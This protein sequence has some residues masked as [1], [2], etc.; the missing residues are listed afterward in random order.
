MAKR[1]S[2]TRPSFTRPPP[3]TSNR[4]PPQAS[5]N[6]LLAALPPEDY[7]RLAPALE[8]V[9]PKLRHIVH[10]PGELLQHVYF[11]G[12]GGFFSV[13]TVLQDGEM[14][15]VATI[16]REGMLGVSA[17]LD[18]RPV[19]SC[20]MV[21]AEMDTCH[22]M[23]VTALR[24]ET[25]RHGALFNLLAQYSQALT[26][27]VMQSTACNAAHLVEQRLARW[28]LHAHDRVGKDQFPLT[29]EFAAMMLGASRPTVTLVAGTLQKAG[30]INYRHG[31]VT[32][33]DREA[34]E[35]ASCE[36]YRAA[37]NLLGDVRP[38]IAPEARSPCSEKRQSRR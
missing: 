14:I 34:L 25:N 37:T 17:I 26:S 2:T 28:L 22:R 15:E 35:S 3:S 6:L 24:R 13:L 16:G 21:Q 10:K 19:P 36:C 20:G 30:L 31:K 5:E 23:T 38:L 27:F 29:Q 1:R 4:P 32:I 9:T 33:V 18:D 7:E 12:G 11:P 8:A